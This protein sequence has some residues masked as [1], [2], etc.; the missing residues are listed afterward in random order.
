MKLWY[1]PL[2]FVIL[3]IGPKSTNSLVLIS[4]GNCKTFCQLEDF[5]SRLGFLG[6]L[7]RLGQFLG[8]WQIFSSDFLAGSVKVSFTSKIFCFVKRRSWIWKFNTHRQIMH[9]DE[10]RNVKNCLH[11]LYQAAFRFMKLW[12]DVH[13]FLSFLILVQKS[14]NSSIFW[15]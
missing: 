15:K 5:L 1:V 12:Y 11:V 10:K 4:G 6:I 9:F 7:V 14:T 8:C 2:I 13:H 3:Y